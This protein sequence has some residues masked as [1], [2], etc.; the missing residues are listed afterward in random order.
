MREF[1]IL[2]S[3]LIIVTGLQR[4]LEIIFTAWKMEKQITVVSIVCVI[5]SY[6]LLLRFVYNNFLEELTAFVNFTF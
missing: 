1:V 4:L 6:F 2:I 3:E 5:I